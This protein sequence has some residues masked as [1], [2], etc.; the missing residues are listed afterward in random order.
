MHCHLFLFSNFSIFHFLFPPP[1]SILFLL[2]TLSPPSPSKIFFPFPLDP[3]QNWALSQ[4][5]RKEHNSLRISTEGYNRVTHHHHYHR[6]RQ[7]HQEA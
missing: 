5:I 2:I 3:Y 4:T 7:H 6:Q 1:P